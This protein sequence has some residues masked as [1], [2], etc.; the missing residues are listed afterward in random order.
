MRRKSKA[1]KYEPVTH[2]PPSEEITIKSLAYNDAK[3]NVKKLLELPDSTGVIDGDAKFLEKKFK[4]FQANLSMIENKMKEWSKDE[5]DGAIQG[6]KD[7]SF[8]LEMS[9][10]ETEKFGFMSDRAILAKTALKMMN[11]ILSEN[12]IKEIIEAMKNDPKLAKLMIS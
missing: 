5:H 2:D 9:S 6:L 11:D 3:Q 1:E 4:P 8:D 7:V 12:T 10:N